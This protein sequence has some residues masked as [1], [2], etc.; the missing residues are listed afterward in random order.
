[1]AQILGVRFVSGSKSDTRW[2]AVFAGFLIC[3]SRGF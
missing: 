2:G 1:M 3:D